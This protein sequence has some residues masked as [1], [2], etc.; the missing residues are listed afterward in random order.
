MKVYIT[1]LNGQI[2]SSTAQKAQNMVTDIAHELGYREL[3]VYAYPI[4]SDTAGE[5]NKRIDGIIAGIHHGDAVIFQTPTWNTTTFDEKLMRKLRAYDIKII[6]FIHDVVP[7][8]FK[9]N[10]YLLDRT[11][12]Y[13]NLA[14]VII[15]PS[16]EMVAI[17]KAHGLK[18]EKIII[19]GMW[20]HKTELTM[21]D[22]K[23]NKEIHF[24]GSPK[25]FPFLKE[26]KYDISLKVYTDL[27]EELPIGVKKVG[28]LSEDELFKEVSKG[29]FGLVWMDFKE[30]DY[31]RWACPY[32]LGLFIAAGVPIIAQNGMANQDFLKKNNLGVFADTLE[33]AIGIIENMSEDEYFELVRSVRKFAPLVRKGFF[34]RRLL[35]EAVFQAFCD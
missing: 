1:N 23:F 27:D 15:A 14:D 33:D 19:Q 13:Y 5:L 6:I 28:F 26:W 12:A 4:D 11:I 22:A 34:T 7:L 17:L 21:K 3:C 10:Y 32:K 30:D 16:Q 9:G 35:T 25:R 24:P 2:L 8:M 18:V 29:S 20:D 31:Y